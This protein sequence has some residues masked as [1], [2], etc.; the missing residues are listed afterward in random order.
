MGSKS[1]KLLYECAKPNYPNLLYRTAQMPINF[2]N[3]NRFRDSVECDFKA[4][5]SGWPTK[6]CGDW[7]AVITW[8]TVSMRALF[9]RDSHD[10]RTPRCIFCYFSCWPILISWNHYRLQHHE[11]YYYNVYVAKTSLMRFWARVRK[12]K[13]FYWLGRNFLPSLRIH[14]SYVKY[15]QTPTQEVFSVKL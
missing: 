2:M 10:C 8:P 7:E 15:A 13:C 9:C 5:R 3:D 4:V 1:L 14:K 11:N 12:L 6:L